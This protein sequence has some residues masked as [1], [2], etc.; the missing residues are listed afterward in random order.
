[1]IRV[2]CQK[3]KKGIG[4]EYLEIIAEYPDMESA[5]F[6]GESDLRQRCQS[7]VNINPYNII[8]DIDGER[9]KFRDRL[10]MPIH[11]GWDGT[12]RRNYPVSVLIEEYP[13]NTRYL[14]S[15]PHIDIAHAQ[16]Q[17]LYWDYVK[18]Y[19]H[20]FLSAY[21]KVWNAYHKLQQLAN[22]RDR[23]II[24][25]NNGVQERIEPHDNQNRSLLHHE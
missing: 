10:N 1:M 19:G 7:T 12:S 4:T 2:Y 16:A 5:N 3:F 11:H 14:Y 9:E 6:H 17:Q 8:V 20:K 25:V 21:P 22:V 15:F 18:M 13:P 23:L 24:F